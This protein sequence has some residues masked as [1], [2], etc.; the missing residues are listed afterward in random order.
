[1]SSRRKVPAKL[2]RDIGERIRAA[3]MTAGFN[4]ATDFASA[5]DIE[6]LTYRRYER[7][8]VIPDAELLVNISN[9]TDYTL[10][11]MIAGKGP[12]RRLV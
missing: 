10:D 11:W 3:R 12:A 9:L 6:P 1:M 2:K 4:T 8:E 5:L 7:G